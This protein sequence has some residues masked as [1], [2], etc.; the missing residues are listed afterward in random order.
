M[1]IA[2]KAI[3]KCSENFINNFQTLEIVQMSVIINKLLHI[4]IMEY[5]LAMKR[6]NK[7]YGTIKWINL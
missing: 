4:R 5:N 2:P 3:H 7:G 6:M 1:H